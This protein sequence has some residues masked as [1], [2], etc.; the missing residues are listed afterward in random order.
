MKWT[1]EKEARARVSTGLVHLTARQKQEGRTRQHRFQITRLRL[2]TKLRHLLL[3]RPWPQQQ[4]RLHL[5]PPLVRLLRRL[6]QHPFQLPEQVLAQSLDPLRLV[7]LE[8]RMRE[9]R[10]SHEDLRDP[11][12]RVGETEALIEP[13]SKKPSGDGSEVDLGHE[14]DG[15]VEECEEEG[16]LLDVG[17]VERDQEGDGV[18]KTDLLDDEG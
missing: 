6:L 16:G 10:D 14:D 13:P 17:V 9:M 2:R 4:Y 7:R 5:L 11:L 12:G 1:E 3:Q 15:E 18:G 8:E